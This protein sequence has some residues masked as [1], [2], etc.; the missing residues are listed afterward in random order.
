MLLVLLNPGVCGR[1]CFIVGTQEWLPRCGVLFAIASHWTDEGSVA[2]RKKFTSL[3]IGLW[4]GDPTSV[5]FF[6]QSS[7]CFA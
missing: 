7:K 6:H 2:C 5:P 1:F 4:V 3:V